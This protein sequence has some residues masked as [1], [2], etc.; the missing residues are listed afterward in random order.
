MFVFNSVADVVRLFLNY[1]RY[2][3]ENGEPRLT[4]SPEGAYF[5][6]P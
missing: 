4:G 6:V 1:Q 5:H 3:N 2:E